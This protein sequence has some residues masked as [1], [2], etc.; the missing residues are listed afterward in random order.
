MRTK[1]MKAIVCT[2]YGGPEVLEMQQVH[3]PAPQANEILVKVHAASVTAADTMMRKGTPLYGR[4]FMGLTK[5]KYPVTG[6]GFAGEVV[7]VGAAVTQFTVGEMLFGES[8]FGGGT[9]AEYVCLAEDSIVT[10]LPAGVSPSTAAS[11]CDGPLTSLNMLRE[12]AELR[13]GQKVLIIGASGSLGT[14]AVQL[15]KHLGAHVTGVCSTVNLGLVKSLGADQVIDYTKTDY[16][17]TG[18]QYDVVYDSVGKSSFRKAKRILNTG[19]VY[20]SPV[21][22]LG[23]LLQMISTKF[24]GSRSA[25]FDATGMKPAIDLKKMLKELSKLLAEGKLISIIDRHYSLEQVAAAHAY[26]DQG[27]KKGNVVITMF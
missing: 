1:K 16:T 18:L 8:V 26:V 3:I 25:R 20:V 7:A 19:G 22:S 11:V 6:T 4:L 27:H 24:V 14:A 17:L 5:P 21:L 12:I 15:A 9:N 23:L 13:P 2:K 10:R